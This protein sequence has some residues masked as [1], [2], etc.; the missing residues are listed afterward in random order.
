[1]DIKTLRDTPPW[2][3]GRD[4]DKVLKKT[5]SDRAADPSDRLTAA[6][7]AGDLVVINDDL[8]NLLVDTVRNPNE[9]EELRGKAAISLGPVLEQTSI[10]EF[11]FPEDVHISEETYD[12][13]RES[14]REVFED[15]SVPKLVRRR[16]LEASVR[17]SDDWHTDAVQTAYASGDHDWMLTAVF[18][19]NYVRLSDAQIMESLQSPDPSIRLHAVEAAGTWE[20]DAAYPHILRLVK[21]SRTPKELRLAAIEAVAGIRPAEAGNVL[22]DLADSDDEEIAEAAQEA[23]DMAEAM[24]DGE[25]DDDE[26]NDVWVN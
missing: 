14:L 2:E 4:A 20:V 21:D 12:H 15:T 8:A 9:P 18:A 22:E 13:I 17:A 11:D 19:M 24:G 10:D 25:D 16:V 6:D 1:M 26:E 3:W 5:L 23:I 7:L